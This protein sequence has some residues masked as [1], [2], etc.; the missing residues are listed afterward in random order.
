MVITDSRTHDVA[1]PVF[2]TFATAGAD[3]EASAHVVP[4]G[5]VVEVLSAAAK[6]AGV[7]LI[8][9]DAVSD[10]VVGTAMVRVQT[11]DGRR[12]AARLLVA[13]DGARSRL[14]AFAGITTVG[15][16]YA[17]RASLLRWSMNAITADA[18][19]N[20]FSRWA[21]RDPAAQGQ[22]GVAGMDR[23]FGNCR[24]VGRQ[25][26][27]GLRRRTRTSL[28]PSPGRHA[29]DRPAARLPARPFDRAGLRAAAFCP[30]RRRRAQRSSDRRQGLN[31]GYRDVA[32]LAQTLVE[33]IAW[34]SISA[35]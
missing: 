15:W 19:R 24:A 3:H 22:A 2:L 21:V 27:A 1:R 30:G 4:D 20:T 13:A 33:A 7:V 16:S 25:R 18:R 6:Q 9:E 32:T 26:S 12:L 14:R 17:S 8:G 34:A 35:R 29:G 31:L 5:V 10:F 23:A 11:R 28:R